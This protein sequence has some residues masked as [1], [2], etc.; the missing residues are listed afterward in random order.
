M[1]AGAAIRPSGRQSQSYA[2]ANLRRASL[3]LPLVLRGSNSVPSR[4]I[5][6]DADRHPTMERF[7]ESAPAEPQAEPRRDADLTV[8]RR[9]SEVPV[10][11]ILSQ[12]SR[13]TFESM[14]GATP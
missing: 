1:G 9:G 13:I 10:F 12:T 3:A 2:Q 4:G 11:Q 14:P 6:T 8:Q 7:P 5:S